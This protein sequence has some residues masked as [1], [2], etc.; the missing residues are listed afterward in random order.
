MP[1]LTCASTISNLTGYMLDY[2]HI[3]E[4]IEVSEMQDAERFSFV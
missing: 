1:L 2:M 3:P 4:D